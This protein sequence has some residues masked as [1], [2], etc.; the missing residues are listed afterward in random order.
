MQKDQGFIMR[1]VLLVV[2]LIALKYYLDFDLIEWLKSPAVQKIIIPIWNF[3]KNI[4]SWV[5]GL[6]S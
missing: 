3:I 5:I 6:V 4:Y 1:I 2:A